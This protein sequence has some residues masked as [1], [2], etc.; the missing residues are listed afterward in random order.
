MSSSKRDKPKWQTLDNFFTKTPSNSTNSDSHAEAQPAA[1]SRDSET[2]KI[3]D[4][5]SLSAASE[6]VS[7]PVQKNLGPSYPDISLLKDSTSLGKDEKLQLLTNKWKDVHTFKF[8]TRDLGNR[9]R[10]LSAKWLTE[11]PWLRYSMNDDAL[12]CAPCVLFGRQESKD[13]LF[14]NKV[15]DWSNLACFVKRHLKDGSPHFTYQAMADD[16]VKVCSKDSKE[17]PIIYKICEYKKTQVNRNRHILLKIMESLLL[18]GKQ[19]I[20]IRGHTPER[21]N[22]H[23]ILNSKAQGDPILTEHLANEDFL[24]FVM[25]TSTKGEHLAELLIETLQGAGVNIAKMRA[26]GYDGAANMSGKYNGVQARISSIIPEAT[27]VHCKSH[28]LNLAVVHSCKDNSV[29]NVMTVVQEIGF[30][31]DYSAKRLQAFFDE[32]SS[33]AATKENMEKRTKLRTLCETRWTSRADALYTFKTAFPVVVHSLERLQ[34]LGDDKAGQHLASLMRFQFVIALVVSEHVLQSTVHLSIF[35]QGAECDLLEAV[36]ECKTVVEMLRSERNDDNTYLMDIGLSLEDF[37]RE[38]ERWRARCRIL[39]RDKVP[40]TLCQTLDIV[41]PALYPSI[42]TILCVLLTMPVASATAE[43]SFSVLKRLK[44]YI[45][46]TMRNDRLSAL[47][48]PNDEMALLI[49]V[50]V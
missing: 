24:D 47:V 15:T 27:Y 1:N 42:D 17:E 32:L 21:S 14:I 5:L 18:C 12:Y 2:S 26:Q 30:A 48:W 44:T 3:D 37:K 13:K 43:R 8:P 16:F 49:V 6:L 34:N 19:N 7:S 9:Q 39:P 4:E 35:L 20:A 29:R 38:V 41:N 25:T 50:A 36:K 40:T 11:N 46:S 23:Y 31:F 45:R 10:R 22:F 33:D 28:C